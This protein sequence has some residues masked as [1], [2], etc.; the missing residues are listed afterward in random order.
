MSQWP[1]QT[2]DVRD[3]LRVLGLYLAEQ[4]DVYQP[5]SGRTG[6]LRGLPYSQPGE[7]PKAD[8][9][10]YLSEEAQA[11]C[12]ADEDEVEGRLLPVLYSFEEFGQQA[13][14]FRSD[15]TA[16]DA[17]MKLATALQGGPVTEIVEAN[18]SEGN[19][20]ARIWLEYENEDGDYCNAY[21]WNDGSAQ[22]ANEEAVQMIDWLRQQHIAANLAPHQYHRKAE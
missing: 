16:Y 15:A 5:G 21:L 9:V 13:Y 17:M 18:Y 4:I 20:R 8:V 11:E 3:Q 10:W 19:G 22:D 2:A 14:R 12:T 7:R 1:Y 6:Q